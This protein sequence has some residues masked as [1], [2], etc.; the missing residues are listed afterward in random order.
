MQP[1]TAKT[2]IHSSR[3][4][5]AELHEALVAALPDLVDWEPEAMFAE[6]GIEDGPRQDYIQ[7]VITVATTDEFWLNPFVYEKCCLALCGQPINSEILQEP[8]VRHLAKGVK[9]AREIRERTERTLEY[10]D[11]D[12]ETYTAVVLHRAGFMLAPEELAFAQEDLEDLNANSRMVNKVRE[13]W[14]KGIPSVNTT[15][16]LED[17]I[18]VQVAKLTEV[19]LYVQLD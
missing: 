18:D 15:L 11:D 17:P 12:V 6:L 14:K 10:P 19:A 16:D 9:F 13:A 1:S 3:I 2:K 4:K 5:P 8:K 7:A